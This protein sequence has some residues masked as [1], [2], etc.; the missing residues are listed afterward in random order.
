M[1][2]VV[3]ARPCAASIV[4]NS[5]PNKWLSRV[6][7]PARPQARTLTRQLEAQ[8]ARDTLPTLSSAL[9]T[10]DGHHMVRFACPV[11]LVLLHEHR[12]PGA[13]QHGVSRQAAAGRRGGSYLKV[14]SPWISC[15]AFAWDAIASVAGQPTLSRC[16][17]KTVLCRYNLHV[18]EIE[19]CL[20]HRQCAAARANRQRA[21]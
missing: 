16:V 5:V 2:R 9:A 15:S 12:Q 19:W 11:Q 21:R 14:E 6:P 20:S 7:T 10:D 4:P 17:G 18:P 13:A 8:P 3:C 1:P